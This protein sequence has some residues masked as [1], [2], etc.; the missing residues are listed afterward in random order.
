MQQTTPIVR[1]LARQ[2]RSQQI[3]GFSLFGAYRFRDNTEAGK[4]NNEKR[5]LTPVALNQSGFLERCNNGA[6]TQTHFL[7][8]FL[9]G[10]C[11]VTNKNS[12]GPV[13]KKKNGAGAS[14]R[15]SSNFK[16]T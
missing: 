2:L 16:V 10:L 15:T 3:G 12:E 11:H 9:G 7:R 5:K 6:S 1:L 13:D 14:T 8:L 4:T